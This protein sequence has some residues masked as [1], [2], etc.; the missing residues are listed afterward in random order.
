MIQPGRSIAVGPGTL[1]RISGPMIPSHHQPG[2]GGGVRT[3]DGQ[4][5]DAR[6]RHDVSRAVDRMEAGYA[7]GG[8]RAWHPTADGAGAAR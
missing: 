8:G 5:A 3:L 6:P 7:R 4:R 1:D 2:A